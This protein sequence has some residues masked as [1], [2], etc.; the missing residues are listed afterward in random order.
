MKIIA[1]AG[2]NS[3]TSINHQFIEYIA[4]SISGIDIIL[5]SDFNIP[6]YGI[7]IE[8]EGFPD[9][10]IKLHNKIRSTEGLIISVAEHNGNVTAFF[11]SIIDWISRYDRAFLADKNWLLLSAAPGQKGGASAL[12][13]A[14]KTLNYFKGELIGTYSLSNFYKTLVDGKII[15]EKV[16]SD[17]DVLIE[18]FINHL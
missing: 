1:F 11:K 8:K 13:I 3:S 14:Q 15:D 17:V 2:S 18:K 6:L 9:G 4:K 5:L 16:K 7:D 10:V 12:A